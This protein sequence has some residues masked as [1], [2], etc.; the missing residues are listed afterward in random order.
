LSGQADHG[1]GLDWQNNERKTMKN[2]IMVWL[3][4]S[5]LLVTFYGSAVVADSKKIITGDGACAKCLLQETKE[6][7]LTITAEEGGKKVTYY[8]TQNNIAK[9]FGD[10][11]CA[12][13]KKV[14]ATGTVKTVDGKQTLVPTKI[15]LA[16]G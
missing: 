1:G 8:L 6:C 15:E 4:V 5:G 11:F 10:Q 3:V 12:E 9:E 7:Q 16:K 13:K 14:K 2:K